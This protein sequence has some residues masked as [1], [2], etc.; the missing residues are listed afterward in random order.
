[1][2]AVIQRVSRAKVTVDDQVVGSIGR[3]LLVLLGVGADD[4]AADASYLAEKIP[5]LRI[6][7]DEAGKLNRSLFEI[8]GEAL[9]VSQF[10][11]YG[12]CRRGRRP[13]FSSAAPPD[14]ARRLY[15][16]F[17]A[18]L[19]EKGIKVATGTFQAHM[20]VELVNDGPVT[21]WL[22]SK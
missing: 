10:T 20:L 14:K 8:E 1:M 7:E 18:Q 5:F 9:V 21:L 16:L 12:D 4:E 22:E 19:Q 17:V 2:R 6:F 13:S 15:E 11:L 3:G